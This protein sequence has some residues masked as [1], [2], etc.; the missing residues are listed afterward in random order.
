M[1][2]R[3]QLDPTPVERFRWLRR[4]SPGVFDTLSA[5]M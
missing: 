5:R 3:G 1:L 4:L 2:A